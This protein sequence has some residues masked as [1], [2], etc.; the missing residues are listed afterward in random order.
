MSTWL[1]IQKNLPLEYHHH[2]ACKYS[3]LKYSPSTTTDINGERQT[4]DNS[5]HFRTPNLKIDPS[6]FG[7]FCLEEVFSTDS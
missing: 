3:I 4:Q 5:G 2:D 6:Q 1:I 7:K